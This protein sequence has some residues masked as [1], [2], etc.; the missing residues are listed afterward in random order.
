M[1]IALFLFLIFFDSKLGKT[2]LFREIC[3]DGKIIKKVKC[4]YIR[5]ES[6]GFW[7][8]IKVV[9]LDM[10]GISAGAHFIQF[11][12]LLCILKMQ[13]KKS[14]VQILQSINLEVSI[15]ALPS[16]LLSFPFAQMKLVVH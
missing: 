14:N 15:T 5:Q 2:K 11:I 3:K 7:G 6:G 16:A 10:G 8:D 1:Q 4:Y 9:L 12:Y 13:Y